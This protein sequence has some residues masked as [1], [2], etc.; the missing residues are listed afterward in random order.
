MGLGVVGDVEADKGPGT[1]ELAY[2]VQNSDVGW[3]LRDQ[4]RVARIYIVERGPE[5]S[6]R[7]RGDCGTLFV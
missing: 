3:V 6:S 5:R 2:G 4:G 7:S 1:T